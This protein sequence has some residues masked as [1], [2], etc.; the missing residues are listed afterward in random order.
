MT[1]P[2][3]SCICQLLSH[4]SCLHPLPHV[5]LCWVLPHSDRLSYLLQI[6]VPVWVSSDCQLQHELAI[7]TFI[8]LLE[9][10]IILHA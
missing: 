4:P 1:A 10:S 3:R 6:E 8:G 7:Q 5:P 2:V 9:T